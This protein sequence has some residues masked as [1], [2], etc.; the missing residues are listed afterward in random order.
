MIKN[1]TKEQEEKFADY[2]NKW[3]AIGTSCEPCNFEESKKYAKMA[4]ESAG[5]V[6]PTKFYLVDSPIAAINL[7][8]ELSNKKSS[9]K[10]YKNCAIQA[11]TGQIYG[12]HEAGWLSYYDFIWNELGVSDCAKL[13]GL[14]GIAKNCGWWSPY[15]DC[16]IFQHRHS[17]LHLDQNGRIHNENGPAV[18]YRDNYSVWA[19]NGVRVNEQ[20][21]MAP[22]TLTV[23]QIDNEKNQDVKSIMVQRFTWARYLKESKASCIDHRDNEV[24]GTKE[25]LYVSPLG[26]NRLVVTC[27]TGRIFS[28]GVPEEITTCAKA[29]FW[30]GGNK[31]INVIGRT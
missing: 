28:L 22:E 31:K 7:V 23:K 10:D 21:I 24:E 29:Q 11:C 20:I 25:A 9:D 26:G 8:L 6:C 19:I 30:L 18:K 12:Y 15:T 1:L 16:V 13:E 5:L 3:I 17:E 4:Y 27:P 14:M 2:R